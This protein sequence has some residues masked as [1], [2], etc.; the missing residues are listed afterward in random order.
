N[1][2]YHWD[3]VGNLHQRI[4][5]RQVLTEQFA[6]D[7][8]SRLLNST[9]TGVT[10]PTLTLTY[11]AS[12]NISSKSDVSSSQYVYDTVHKHAV[13]TAG[14]WSMTYDNNGNMI[15][16]GVGGTISYYSYNLPNTI[17]Y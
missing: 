10:N 7:S 5:N 13:K 6:Y 2:S 1:L 16:R 9:L 4:D 14:S 17:S 3:P 8:M 12:G 15:T 11:S